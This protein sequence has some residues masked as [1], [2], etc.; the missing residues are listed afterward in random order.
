MELT[1]EEGFPFSITLELISKEAKT[2]DVNICSDIQIEMVQEY[3]ELTNI[4]IDFV[5]EKMEKFLRYK[6]SESFFIK[7][8][9]DG[10]IIGVFHELYCMD[11]FFR[12]SCEGQVFYLVSEFRGNNMFKNMTLVLL[13]IAR[14]QFA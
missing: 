7:R 11:P 2:E 4:D 6:S 13:G 12:T 5:K 10:K 3:G 9:E 14:K 8:K 1:V